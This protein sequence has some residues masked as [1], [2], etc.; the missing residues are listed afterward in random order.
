MW[1]N[2][3]A[4]VCSEVGIIVGTD[5]T[6]LLDCGIVL[7]QGEGAVV[8]LLPVVWYF[9]DVFDVAAGLFFVLPA[10]TLGS[11]IVVT[12]SLC[13]NS[14]MLFSS[15]LGSFVFPMSRLQRN[16]AARSLIA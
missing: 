8:L 11:A 12:F 7:A 15:T 6:V 16:I 5:R 1:A 10:C 4:I 14:L 13:F 2:S 9:V 3:C